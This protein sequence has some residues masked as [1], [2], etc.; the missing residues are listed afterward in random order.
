MSAMF[1]VPYGIVADTS[2]NIIFTDLYNHCIRKVNPSGIITTI[3]GTPTVSGYSGDGGPAAQA[4]LNTPSFIAIGTN[5]DLYWPEWP[6]RIVRKLNMQTG[7]ISTVAG[8]NTIGYSGDGGFATNAQF[9]HPHGVAVDAQGNL[10]IADKQAHV[11]RKVD[12]LGVIS[13]VVGTGIAG[14]SGDGGLATNAQLNNP[15]CIASDKYG[16]I[17][18]NDVGNYRIRR[19]NYNTSEV[20]TAKQINTLTAYPNPS[21]DKLTLQYSE[22]IKSIEILTVTGKVEMNLLPTQNPKTI[23]L[24]ISEL[25]NGMHIA[26]VNGAETV[27]FMKE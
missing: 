23:L 10:F 2:G 27:S 22:A 19:I 18:I 13:T 20:T 8:N 16:N 17:Y 6:N 21:T 3:A 25:S 14:F 15:N 12:V 11:V 9:K 24:N 4:K 26:K 1:K 7:I 5:G